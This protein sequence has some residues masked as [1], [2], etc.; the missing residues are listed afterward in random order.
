MDTQKRP[1]LDRL[2][3]INGCWFLDNSTLEYL[4]TCN[5]SGEYYVIRRRVGA[6]EKCALNFGS[7]IHKALEYRYMTYPE[8]VPPSC[9]DQINKILAQWFVD[10]PQPFDDYRQLSLA[11][12]VM[13]GY[14]NMPEYNPEPFVV[15]HVDGK[16]AVEVPFS[17]ELCRLYSQKDGWITVIFCGKIDLIVAEGKEF[18]VIDHKTTKMAGKHFLWEQ[19][20]SAQWKGYCHAVM[21]ATG[22]TPA[23]AIIDQIR[24]RE[25]NKTEKG[26]SSRKA[27]EPDDFERYRFALEPHHI[28]EWKDNIIGILK[29]FLRCYDEGFFPMETKWCIGKYGPCPYLEI[30]DLPPV[31][32]TG[33]LVRE[34]ALQTGLCADDTFTPLNKIKLEHQ[35]KTQ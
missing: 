7:A 8:L 25:P 19:K 22:I 13:N 29:G 24:V 9:M 31:G 23:G 34:N 1:F 32:P 15:A 17:I 30:C 35:N 18:W 4:Q 26:Q 14:L 5:R 21:K 16:L 12:Q 28:P 6:G 33:E 11:V 2:H 10:H 27:V 20:M 3:L